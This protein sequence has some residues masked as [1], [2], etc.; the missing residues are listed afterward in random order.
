MTGHHG[1]ET[2]FELTTIQ[3]LERLRYQPVFGM[4]I[5]RSHHEVVLR[6]VL[7]AQLA[8]RYDDLPAAALDEAVH[9]ISRP[10][11]VDTLRRNLAF[12][13]LLTRGFDLKVPRPVGAQ[14]DAPGRES[15]TNSAVPLHADEFEYRH[16]YPINWDE[17]AKNDFRVI[18]QFPIHGQN[19]R[20]PDII[21][22]IN[23]LPLVLFELKNPYSEKP[24]VEDAFNQIQHYSYEIPQVFDFNALTVIS[25]GV[26]TLHGVWTGTR[27]WYSPW[28]SIDGFE[29]EPNTTGSMKTLIEGLF[30]KERLL[31]Y[32]R[33]FLVFEVVNEKITKKGAR[34]HQFF[35]VR[36][37]VEKTLETYARRSPDR[38]IGVIWHTT[39]S[40][41]SLSMAFLVGILRR[42]AELENPIFLIEVDRND[43]DKQLYDQFLAARQLVGEVQQAD[44]VEDL[45]DLLQTAG[46]EVI[47]STIEKFRLGEGETS[48]PALNSRSNIIL[49]ADEAH[50]SQY[51]FAEGFARSLSEALPNAMRLGFTGTPIS[52]S[53]ADTVQVF[54]D[55]IHTYDIQQSQKDHATVPIYYEPRQLRL[56]QRN[57]ALEPQFRSVT[58]GHDQQNINQNIGRWTALAAITRSKEHVATLAQDL[59]EH[60]TDRTRT[61]KGKALIVCMERLNCVRLYEAL[62]VL[63]GCPEIKIIMTGNLSEDPPEWSQKGYLTTKAQREAIK[64]RM[65]DPAD[66][67]QMVIVCDMWLT[68]TD[69]PC[70]HTLYVDKPMEGHNMIQAISRVNRVFSDKPHG[71]IVDYIGIGDALREATSHYTRKD[72]EQTDVAAE[73]GEKA[74]PLFFE[75]LDET[76]SALPRKNYANWRAL[77]EI[78]LEDLYSL[79]YGFLCADDD[80]RE[81]FLQAEVRLSSAFLLVM[82]LDDCRKHADEIIFYQRVRKQMLKTTT[83]RQTERDLDRAVQD[84]VDDS[85]EPLGVVDIFKAAGIT[86]P[87]ISILDDAFL[88]TFKDRPPESLQVK[89]LERLLAD[90]IERRRRGNVT[91]ARSFKQTLEQT[92]QDYH[93]RLIDAKEVIE[94]MIAMKQKMEAEAQ[95]AEQLHLSGEEIAFYDAIAANVV[96]IYDQAFL[97]DLIH[98]VVQTLKRNLKV[99]WAEAHR[100]DIQADIR[101]AVKRT[102]KRRKVREEDLEP[103]IGSILVQ[104]QALYADWP[105]GAFAE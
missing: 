61:L 65:K 60:F 66:P 23:G 27:E 24:T 40:G 4:E 25:D 80:Q 93:N 99:D 2:E 105:L 51:G 73:I 9:T 47:F 88:Q 28:K 58:A 72:G 6:D 36:L 10:V 94:Q 56:F 75:A 18:N 68:G 33:D 17:P 81:A 84:L 102:L 48:H 100:A 54:G 29:I 78:D 50:R 26:T 103:F 82:S 49:I 52:L 67:L 35:A 1:T 15:I 12:H 38:R 39:G 95:R 70:L 101:A 91:R 13:Q 85:L 69:I 42:R 89:L 90:E 92:L 53:G 11:G 97:C 16:I 74:R 55:L 21:I 3:R 22:F 64:E 5:E 44:S 7:H 62:T 32:I 43:L 86:R 87:D 41:K 96:S 14:R 63:P 46:G 19:D 45:R 37:A 34:Y 76:R 59:L 20:R 79:V 104:A 98:E 31:Q 77:S 57:P 71:L 8:A 83:P 30:P